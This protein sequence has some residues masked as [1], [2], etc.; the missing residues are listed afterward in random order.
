MGR[1]QEGTSGLARM[2]GIEQGGKLR[3]RGIAQQIQ[4]QAGPEPKALGPFL[5]AQ[6][7]GVGV[8]S[9]MA[10]PLPLVAPGPPHPAVQPRPLWGSHGEERPLAGPFIVR[11]A[12]RCQPRHRLGSPSWGCQRPP[13]LPLPAPPLSH[14]LEPQGF[15]PGPG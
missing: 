10:S 12:R 2:P 13:P 14:F 9:R 3:P 8:S 5:E 1:N 4:V 7:L 15:G 11:E 6:S